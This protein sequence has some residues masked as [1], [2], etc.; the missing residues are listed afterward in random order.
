M[1][2]TTLIAGI[3]LVLG[4]GMAGAA[5]AQEVAPQ[6]ASYLVHNNALFAYGQQTINS[7]HQRLGDTGVGH[8]PDEGNAEFFVRGFGGQS[9]YSSD[10]LS[11]RGGL[12]YEQDLYGLQLGGNWLN[13][14]GENNSL[15]LG[16]AVSSGKSWIEPV[17]VSGSDSADEFSRENAI[18]NSF[19][20]TATWQHDAGWYV[21]GLVG[22]TDYRSDIDTPFDDGRLARLD[23]SAVLASVETGYSWVLEEG[24]VVE[25]QAQVSWQ[26][27]DT[28]RVSD[29]DGVVVDLGTPELFVWRVGA[30]ALFAPSAGSDGSTLTQYVKFNYYDSEG[31]QQRAILSGQRVDTGEYG[32]TAEFG[33]GLTA[34]LANRFSFFGD[35][36]LQQDIA[37]ASR[38]G[39]AAS[40]GGKW[41][42]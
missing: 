37:D 27:L 32:R 36:A 40:V 25:P 6:T 10:P 5:S 38:E 42:F 16:A 4:L 7:L 3:Q 15:R 33:Y 30:R 11:P 41:V 31:P 14:Q 26:K 12:D 22:A 34:T 1:K 39:W 8:R 21:D 29:A 24:L 19:V 2:K 17:L 35:F 20:A 28:D 18:A 9:R 13:L 23:S